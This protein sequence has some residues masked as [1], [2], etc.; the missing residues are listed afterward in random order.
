[1]IRLFISGPIQGMEDK[2][3]YRKEM[4]RILETEGYEVVDPWEREKV[5]YRATEKE[6]WRNVPPRDFI[7]RDL[8]DIERCDVLIAY[9]PTL[10][11]G[12]CMELFYAKLKGKKVVSIIEFNNPS[13]WITLHSDVVLRSLK[14]FESYVKKGELKELLKKGD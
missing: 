9:L 4:R 10:S 8:R 11:A 2:Q 6:W 13:P 7:E 14:E 1:M 5:I 3:D 12:T